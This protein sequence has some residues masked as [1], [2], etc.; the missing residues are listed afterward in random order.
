MKTAEKIEKCPMP[1]CRESD[2]SCYYATEIQ[3]ESKP[4]GWSVTCH[5]CDAWSPSFKTRQD[6]IAWWNNMSRC[7]RACEGVDVEKLLECP[8][9]T[10]VDII[11]PMMKWIIF[12]NNTVGK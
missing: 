4:R 2:V 1:G 12:Q 11:R 5:G 3:C 6:A 7:I 9:W 8:K 10:L